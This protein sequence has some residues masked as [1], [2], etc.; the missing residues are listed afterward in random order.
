METFSRH[1]GVMLCGKYAQSDKQ[2]TDCFIYIAMNMHWEG[3]RLALPKL[4]K[5]MCWRIAFATAE[6]EDIS[7]SGEEN[8]DSGVTLAPRSIAVLSSVQLEKNPGIGRRRRSGN[9]KGLET[10]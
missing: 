4:P 5:G 1:V 3:H 7:E 6:T 2:G 8:L 9:G 10:F